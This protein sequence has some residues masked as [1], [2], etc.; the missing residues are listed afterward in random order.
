MPD[1]RRSYHD[2]YWCIRQR[3]PAPTLV[4]F[5]ST[6]NAADQKFPGWGFASL[7]GVIADYKLTTNSETQPHIPESAGRENF[8]S[9]VNSPYHL[10]CLLSSHAGLCTTDARLPSPGETWSVPLIILELSCSTYSGNQLVPVLLFGV[11]SLGISHW[12]IYKQISLE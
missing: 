9:I 5:Q 8:A 3:C 2:V 1:P 12:C 10:S 7:L 4:Q 11:G 6:T